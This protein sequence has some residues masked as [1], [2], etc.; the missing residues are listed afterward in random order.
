[1][2][3]QVIVFSEP[4]GAGLD[5][6]R[7]F[8]A[9]SMHA[10]DGLTYDCIERVRVDTDAPPDAL[11]SDSTDT[12][13][14]VD[15]A[16]HEAWHETTYPWT[17]SPTGYDVIPVRARCVPTVVIPTTVAEVTALRYITV[18]RAG[19][20]LG[21]NV[22]AAGRVNLGAIH[23]PA[24]GFG[25]TRFIDTPTNTLNEVEFNALREDVA[26]G[27]VRFSVGVEGAG[28]TWTLGDLD[29]AYMA[30]EIDYGVTA[31]VPPLR[32]FPRD[33]ELASGSAARHWP[34]SSEQ[35]S[36]RRLGGY[37]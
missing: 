29:V 17:E 28:L 12:Y 19:G 31:F 23:H 7:Y 25:W 37:F 24:I 21:V 4:S 34:A 32:Q 14:H 9:H 16:A 1:M 11:T 6:D 18:V 22:Q 5:V 20:D 35:S 2:P 15:Q 8:L 26:A 13:A 3:T 36:L 27:A 33:D 30:L 10:D